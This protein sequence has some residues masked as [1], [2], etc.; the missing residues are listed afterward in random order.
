M[1]QLAHRMQLRATGCS[2][3]P[4]STHEMTATF[5]NMGLLWINTMKEKEQKR[6]KKELEERKQ[7]Q[8]RKGK[9]IM[10]SF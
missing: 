7:E 4:Q 8:T 5:C 2:V 1:D 10:K 3:Q 9:E 6:S